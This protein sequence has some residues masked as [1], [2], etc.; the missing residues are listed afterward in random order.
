MLPRKLEEL[1]FKFEHGPLVPAL[2]ELCEPL[3]GN[4]HE[5]I[6]R[7]L[8]QHELRALAYLT[9][10]IPVDMRLGSKLANAFLA[11]S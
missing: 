9:L 8:R 4:Q 6:A 7:A 5:L 10:K 2:E 1:G 11:S 3:R